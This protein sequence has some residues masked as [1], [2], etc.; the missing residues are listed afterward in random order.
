MD[1]AEIRNLYEA[2]VPALVELC[3]NLEAAAREALAAVAHV[4]R[5]SGRVKA[6][7][8]FVR[9]ALDPQKSY[10]DPLE[11]IE[12][13]VALRVLVFFNGDIDPVVE[14]LRA[15][16]PP[17]EDFRHQPPRDEE[18]GYLT[19]HVVFAIPDHHVPSSWAGLDHAP[20]TFETQVRTLFMHAYAEPQHDLS[21]KSS[22]EL[23]GETRRQLAWIA[24]SAWGA[25]RAY[26][27]VALQIREAAKQ[28]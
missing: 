12:D 3:T 27:D 9:K 25:D 26:E 10:S 4:D 21:Y 28:N 19:H 23:S 17:I 18:F 14:R 15:T 22:K 6:Q 1:E 16:F 24:A 13:Q 11:E 2:R 7:A 8:S 20:K 5:I